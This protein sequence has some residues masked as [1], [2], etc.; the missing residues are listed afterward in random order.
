MRPE[1][2]KG[3]RPVGR[4]EEK[5]LRGR[6]FVLKEAEELVIGSVLSYP[7]QYPLVHFLKAEDFF[8]RKHAKIWKIASDLYEE[9]KTLTPR[10]V[11]AL[12]NASKGSKEDPLTEE[13]LEYLLAQRDA[14]A[15]L[16]AAH[17]LKDA[18]N[19]RYL[20]LKLQ[21]AQSKLEMGEAPEAVL[22]ELR[23]AGEDLY[24]WDEVIDGLDLIEQEALRFLE[25]RNYV[26]TGI[27]EVDEL[28][29]GGFAK[30]G[31]TVL[32]ARPSMGKTALARFIVR[33]LADRGGKVYWASFDQSPEQILLLEVA[34][35]L[36]MPLHLLKGAYEQ[37]PDLRKEVEK[38]LR[39]LKESWRNKVQLDGKLAP[40]EVLLQR[41]WRAHR[42]APLDMVVVDYLQFVP[43]LNSRVSDMER[44]SQVSKALKGFAVEAKVAV[45]AIAQLSREV[46]R[47]VNK[48]PVLADLRDSGQV[49]QDADVILFLHRPAYYDPEQDWGRAEII[50][51][52]NKLGPVGIATVR[53]D[54]DMGEFL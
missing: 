38:E 4:E 21:E 40:V 31:M 26:P 6:G 15:L 42:R 7:E 47:R 29:S 10:L 48:R 35:R 11:L 22:D 32:A 2:F 53:W 54:P 12:Y 16:Q 13:E 14:G 51:G 50:I 9:G 28:L 20:A 34:K 41:L 5:I 43:V 23:K 36:G 37:D 52:K 39:A 17:L 46:E 25:G 49:E 45:V 8:Y 44:V 27:A 24:A 33:Q 3:P 18:S 1:G 19:R 30:G